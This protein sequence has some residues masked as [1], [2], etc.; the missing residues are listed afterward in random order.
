MRECATAG[1]ANMLTTFG[2][3]AAVDVA[4]GAGVTRTGEFETK[5][6]A[7]GF[8][9]EAGARVTGAW[10]GM[11]T[12]GGATAAAEVA[13]LSFFCSNSIFRSDF[14]FSLSMLMILSSALEQR[15]RKTS[16]ERF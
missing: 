10:G 7:D 11:A 1:V 8:K 4:A 12:G 9:G 3:A 13:L 2:V 15:K 16:V 6:G 14:F 5:T